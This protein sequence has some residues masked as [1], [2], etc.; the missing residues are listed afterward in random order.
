VDNNIL[1]KTSVIQ[2]HGCGFGQ[3]RWNDPSNVNGHDILD[4][5]CIHRSGSKRIS[6]IGCRMAYKI[7]RGLSYVRLVKM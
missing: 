3:I 2:T 6:K 7:I 4:F 1:Y 5:E